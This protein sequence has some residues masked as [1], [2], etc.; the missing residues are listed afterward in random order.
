MSAAVRKLRKR[1]KKMSLREAWREHKSSLVAYI[2][3]RSLVIVALVLQVLLRN[4]ENVF[5]CAMA[6]V[7]LTVPMFIEK[8]ISIEIPNALEIIIYCFIFASVILGEIN[9]FYQ[10]VPGWDTMLHTLNGFLC[11]GVGLSLVN[12]L[13]NRDNLQFK[14]SPFYVALAAFCF[15]MTIGVLWE[16]YEFGMDHFLHTDMQKDTIINA[17][18]TVALDSTKSNK[19]V[20][21]KNIKDVAING[22]DLGL[23][24]Y[25]DIGL[26]DTM[27]DMFVN[28]IGAVT[29]SIFGY[30]Y[31]K[32]EEKYKFLNGFIPYS[33]S[34]DVKHVPDGVK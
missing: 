10:R 13:N 5:M 14:L 29:F 8:K 24:G 2:V 1:E 18:Y 30:F 22:K 4:F 21:L 17:V 16:F 34:K 15:S 9:S 33:T 19:V 20:A 7:L 25:L 28:F 26:I 6:L 32:H 27:K 11:A 12:L 3:F 31:A 23:G